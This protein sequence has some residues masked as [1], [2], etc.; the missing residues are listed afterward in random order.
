M[1]VLKDQLR[2]LCD[3]EQQQ[4][5]TLF[6]YKPLKNENNESVLWKLDLEDYAQIDR[7]CQFPTLKLVIRLS[8]HLFL[9]YRAAK[10]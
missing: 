10:K 5:G 9:Y 7:F 2:A 1:P 6:D 4:R 3:A 8:I